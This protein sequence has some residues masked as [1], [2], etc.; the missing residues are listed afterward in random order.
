VNLNLRP[1]P[2]QVAKQGQQEPRE[3]ENPTPQKNHTGMLAIPDP[4][5][6]AVQDKWAKK[7]RHNHR[8]IARGAQ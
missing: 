2:Q 6:S 8:A 3:K 7:D 4:D 5:R 1:T